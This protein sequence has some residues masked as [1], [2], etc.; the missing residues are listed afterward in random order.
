VSAVVTELGV[1]EPARGQSVD[2]LVP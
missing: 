1:A 2:G